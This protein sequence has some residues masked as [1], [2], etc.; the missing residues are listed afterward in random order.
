MES[1]DTLNTTEFANKPKEGFKQIDRNYWISR[2]IVRKNNFLTFVIILLLSIGIYLLGAALCYLEFD[3]FTFVGTSD[4][5]I[6]SYFD[7]SDPEDAIDADY[8]WGREFISTPIFLFAHLIMIWVM[9]NSLK[10]ALLVMPKIIDIS[11]E[12]LQKSATKLINNVRGLIVASPFIL[13]DMYYWYLDLIDEEEILINPLLHGLTGGIW[14]IE[15]YIFGCILNSLIMY[16][17]FIRKYILKKKYKTDLISAVIERELEG[18][19]L[20]GYKISFAFGFFFIANI[21]FLILVEPWLSDLIAF[22]I[23]F[24]MLPIIS[25]LPIKFI[26]YDT[27]REQEKWLEKNTKQFK[28]LSGKFYE[29]PNYLTLET[30]VNLLM[31]YR[32]IE[33]FEKNQIEFWTVYRRILFVLSIPASYFAYFLFW[34]IAED[35]Y[36][37]LLEIHLKIFLWVFKLLN[38]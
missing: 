16:I 9:G 25:I 7:L 24:I 32:L 5:Y 2:L 13:Y 23:L 3:G 20:V 10:A 30:K 12:E 36:Y 11:H 34:Q 22:L 19:V 8:P 38:V 14:V 6:D 29:D 31:N 27:K 21:A 18:L 1:K 37:Q 17:Q 4:K 15:W 26:E 28:E 33:L 35:L